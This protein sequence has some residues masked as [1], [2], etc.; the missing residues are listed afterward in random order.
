MYCNCLRSDNGSS[1]QL[2]CSDSRGAAFGS[3]IDESGGAMI[4]KTSVKEIVLRLLSFNGAVN[5]SNDC[6]GS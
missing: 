4:G 6:L 5:C 1:K 2:N 3:R